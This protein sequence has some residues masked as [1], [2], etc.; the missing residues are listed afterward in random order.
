M[1]E[2]VVDTLFNDSFGFSNEDNTK[3]KKAIIFMV[4]WGI[5]FSQIMWRF[6]SK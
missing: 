3:D 6:G 4:I 5:H 2:D 1:A